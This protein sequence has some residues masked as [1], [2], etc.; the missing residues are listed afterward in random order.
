M[1]V[2]V[3]QLAFHGDQFQTRDVVDREPV[4]EAVHT[5]G[6]FRHIAANGAGNLRGRIRRIVEAV[7]SYRLGNSQVWHTR[8]D[9]GPSVLR[10]DLQD[11]VQLAEHQQHPPGTWQGT[12]GE[13]RASTAG[14]HRH[15]QFVAQPHHSLYLF[16]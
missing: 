14:N 7:G 8:L 6:I 12:T 13:T 11:A 9:P 5:A 10:I 2:D 15:L 16:H 3:Q 1:A 4:L